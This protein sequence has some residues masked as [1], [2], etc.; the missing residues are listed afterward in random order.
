M[1]NTRK[2]LIGCGA[3]LVLG[4]IAIFAV[5]YIAVARVPRTSKA[6]ASIE[7][8]APAEAIRAR[9][10]N[11]ETWSEW[12]GWKRDVDSEVVR[13]F[14]EHE[15]RP[16]ATVRWSTPKAVRIEVGLPRNSVSSVPDKDDLGQGEVKLVSS[17]ADRVELHTLFED[18]LVIA[19]AD[20]DKSGVAAVRMQT[21]GSHYT[22][23]SL[24]RL[25]ATS[26]G[27]RVTWTDELDLG[28]GFTRGMLATFLGPASQMVHREILAD[29]LQ[30]LKV[31]VEPQSK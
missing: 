4:A 6:E 15:G 16:G 29:S 30:G 25:E 27:T 7:I 24:V 26:G 1:S 5:L 19:G 20:R 18:G 13:T 12:S 8:A 9:I 3:A 28:D 21:P 10:E 14:G 17:A 11:L 23:R 2:W 31:V 22:I